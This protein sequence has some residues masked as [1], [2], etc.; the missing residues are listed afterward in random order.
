MM[1]TAKSIVRIVALG[2]A[3]AFFVGA[4]PRIAAGAQNAN[5]AQAKLVKVQ[6]LRRAQLVAAKK[7]SFDFHKPGLELT[8]EIELPKGKQLID[9]EQP[10]QI[11]AS[12]SMNHDLTNIEDNFMGHKQYVTFMRT[13]DEP[14]KEVS[15]QLG[16]P[17]RSATRFNLA[18]TFD[19]WAYERIE[20]KSL[21]L[22]TSPTKLDPALF[23]G[24]QV[25]AR[26][27]A[28]GS[29]M[30]VEFTPGTIKQFIE[31][32]K[33]KDGADEIDNMGAMWNNT[34]LSYSFAAKA[35]TNVQVELTLRTGTI[36]MPCSIA[37]K[38]QPL[39]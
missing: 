6:E 1:H 26:V 15:V 25:S 3:V 16:S 17:G 31:D 27:A 2:A 38:D 30:D 29:H 35:G 23:G 9:V 34:A 24:T 4:T 21:T 8:F 5:R 36:K 39:P 13:F 20:K 11:R 14:V 7:G 32:I 28:T 19:V 12:D 37:I 10:E 33:V 22:G 18:T